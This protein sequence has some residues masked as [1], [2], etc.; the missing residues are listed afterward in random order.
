[1]VTNKDRVRWAE[2]AVRAHPTFIG[3]EVLDSDV[4]NLL[5]NL[6][7]WAAANGHNFDDLAD[8]AALFHA[9]EAAEESRAASGM[10]AQVTEPNDAG[11]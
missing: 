10:G 6:M 2:A 8:T 3:K 7:H 9:N 11:T 1:M 4:T 5:A